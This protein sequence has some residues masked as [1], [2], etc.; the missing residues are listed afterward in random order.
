M[1]GFTLGIG[2]LVLGGG[3]FVIW[4]Y[5]V[6]VWQDVIP[7]A[8]IILTLFLCGCGLFLLRKWAAL[9]VSALSLCV[10]SWEIKDGIRYSNWLGFL[11]ALIFLA[12]TIVTV[13]YWRTLSWT[14]K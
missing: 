12:P 5:P 7:P 8:I 13:V 9:I 4:R 3:V 2:L 14:A 10:A 6:R 1:G 11:F